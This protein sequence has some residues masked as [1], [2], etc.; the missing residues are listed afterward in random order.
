MA[1][2]KG[3]PNNLPEI[4]GNKELEYKLL[5]YYF[6]IHRI[7]TLIQSPIRMDYN[8]SFHIYSSTEGRVKWIDYGSR[9]GGDIWDLLSRYWK[10]T[11]NEVLL[12]VSK[13]IKKI[14]GDEALLDVVP[15]SYT[16][17]QVIHKKEV[18]LQ[19]KVRDW[20]NYDLEFWEGYGI[21]L[22][23]L[24]F[25]QVY[26]VSQLIITKNNYTR[27]IPSDKY[28]YAYVEF[29]D[30]RHTFKIYQPFSKNYKWIS[31][32]DHSIWDLWAQLPKNGDNLIITSSRKDALCLWENTGIPATGLQGEGYLP[33]DH[34]VQELKNRFKN[35]FVLY[36]NDF[37]SEVN[38]G[39]FY[40][41]YICKTFGLRQVEIP[42]YLHS[43]DPSDLCKNYGRKTLRDTILNLINP[44]E[45]ESPF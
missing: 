8:P 33:K 27:V 14:Q 42:T 2:A 12:R 19:V 18:D 9:E 17:G 10:C 6:N 36:D 30:N 24:R 1:F 34:V 40:G 41:E 21:S 23:W 5:S 7:P 44:L 20:K 11:L 38:Y 22:P 35:I 28:A 26:P 43:K 45:E 4:L 39:K 15:S 29:K 31:K 37:R 3:S 13:D 32:H 25:G 16:K